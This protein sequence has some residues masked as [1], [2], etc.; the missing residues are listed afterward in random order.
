M[1]FSNHNQ[2]EKDR[3]IYIKEQVEFEVKNTITF[4]LVPPEEISKYKS[5]KTYTR[6]TWGKLQGSDGKKNQRRISII[7]IFL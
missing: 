6:S 4:I 5:S 3:F 7:N 1:W 2:R